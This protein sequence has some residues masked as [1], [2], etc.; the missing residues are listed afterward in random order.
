MQRINRLLLEAKRTI[1]E[2]ILQVATAFIFPNGKGWTVQI[3]LWDG[4]PS[5]KIDCITADFDTMEEAA[6]FIDSVQAAHTPTFKKNKIDG[7]TF[8][9][10]FEDEET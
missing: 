7:V 3:N 8:I 9:D 4:V 5:G 2:G 10:S 1:D 6:N